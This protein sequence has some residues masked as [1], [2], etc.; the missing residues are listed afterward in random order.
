MSGSG[1]DR[2]MLTIFERVNEINMI[3]SRFNPHSFEVLGKISLS[4]R[5]LTPYELGFYRAISWLYAL[6]F[7][8]DR[9][10]VEFLRD[11]LTGYRIEQNENHVQVVH[12]LRTYLQHNLDPTKEQNRAI[13]YACECW[14]QKQCQVPVPS[15]EP[16][17]RLCL[18]RLLQDA[19]AF[20]TA[21]QDCIRRIE[22][23]EGREDI[24]RQWVFRRQRYHLPHEFD[25]LISIAA[26][27]MGRENIDAPRFRKRYY[28]RWMRELTIQQGSYDFEVEGRK[29]IEHAL[30]VET[31]PVL[32]ITG[33][34]IIDTFAISPGPQVGELLRVARTLYMDEPCSRDA[35]LTRLRLTLQ[36]QR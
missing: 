21:L 23:D 20:L 6:Y 19:L 12:Q 9:V 15:T 34:D 4:V 18:Q 3:G 13:Q 30:L 1:P 17:W 26:T 33:K 14:F 32:P 8:S 29:L 25:R 27:D 10:N 16:Q 22:Q 24:L 31:T 5:Q 11:Q 2:L 35:L 28:D 36:P 7:E